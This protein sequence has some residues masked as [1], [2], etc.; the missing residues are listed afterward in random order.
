MMLGRAWLAVSIPLFAV[1][2][3]AVVRLALGLVRFAREGAI[4]SLPV[5]A[6]QSLL[7][8][9]TDRY[10]VSMQGKFGER[11][12][13][14]LRFVVTDAD[15][16]ELRL[17][18]TYTRTTVSSLDGTA[19]RDLFSFSARAGRHVIRTVGIDPG[20][21]YRTSRLVI[22]RARGRQLVVRIVALLLAGALTVGS[23]VAS[24]LLIVRR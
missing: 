14:E 5:I 18:P 8:P 10:A 13:G 23:L 15:G 24:L 11:E 6:E 12:F 3:V 21:D 17:A 1:G 16:R 9:D 7:L 20:R 2:I 19:R 4:A 22:G